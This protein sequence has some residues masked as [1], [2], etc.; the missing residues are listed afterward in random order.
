MRHE[1]SLLRAKFAGEVRDGGEEKEGRELGGQVQ[2]RPPASW[3][4]GQD[5]AQAEV[6]APATCAELGWDG[7]RQGGQGWE[8]LGK[9]GEWRGR[10]GRLEPDDKDD[11]DKGTGNDFHITRS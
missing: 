7:Q 9:G 10:A 6:W 3:A 4:T 1:L 2:S 5:L 11:V 8:R